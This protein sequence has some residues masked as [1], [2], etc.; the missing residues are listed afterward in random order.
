M[1]EVRADH[2][3]SVEV[4]SVSDGLTIQHVL[5]HR[6]IT[7]EY[8]TENPVTLETED[9]GTSVTASSEV[10]IFYSMPTMSGRWLSGSKQSIQTQIRAA[11]W[12]AAFLL[13]DQSIGV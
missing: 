7:S 4:K 1:Q 3:K 9:C 13:T 12:C 11:P 2:L 6:D 10:I 5:T 8:C